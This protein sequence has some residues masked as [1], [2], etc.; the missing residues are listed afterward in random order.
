MESLF[1]QEDGPFGSALPFPVSLDNSMQLDKVI[2]HQN[3]IRAA[4]DR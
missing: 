2:H 1:Y 4:R 3:T